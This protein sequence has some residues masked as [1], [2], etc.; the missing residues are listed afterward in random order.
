MLRQHLFWRCRD[1]NSY[2]DEGV[3]P[4]TNE[5]MTLDDVFWRAYFEG[6][7]GTYRLILFCEN[8]GEAKGY[9]YFPSGGSI[10]SAYEGRVEI[11]STFVEVED[12]QE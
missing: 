1:C 7:G 3:T 11:L 12:E 2:S 10:S 8:C 5:K 9:V 6:S 4:D